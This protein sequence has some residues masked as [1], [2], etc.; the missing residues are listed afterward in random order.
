MWQPACQNPFACATMGFT[1]PLG[2]GRG[3]RINRVL[4]DLSH[5]ALAVAR[6][7]QKECVRDLSA[8]VGAVYWDQ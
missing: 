6:V 8:A 1:Q 5:K 7:D 4:N 3:R 2:R